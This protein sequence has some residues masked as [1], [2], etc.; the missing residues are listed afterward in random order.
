MIHQC[1]GRQWTPPLLDTAL[2][3]TWMETA[4]FYKFII[5]LTCYFF[6]TRES[7]ITYSQRPPIPAKME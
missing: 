2:L 3:D 6:I 1:R 4:Y 7:Q 5:T